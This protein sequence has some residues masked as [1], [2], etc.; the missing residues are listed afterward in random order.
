MTQKS[1]AD[2]F[3][4]QLSLPLE[5]LKAIIIKASGQAEILRE[6]TGILQC[7]EGDL[8]EVVREQQQSVLHLNEVIQSFQDRGVGP[9]RASTSHMNAAAGNEMLH[10]KQSLEILRKREPLQGSPVGSS[11]GSQRISVGHPA[12]LKSTSEGQSR[13]SSTQSSLAQSRGELDDSSSQHKCCSC[14]SGSQGHMVAQSADV[15]SGLKEIMKAQCLTE[16]VKYNGKNS[17]GDFLRMMD[18]KYPK[19]AWTDSERRDILVT[20]LEGQAKMLY[21]TLPKEVKEGPYEGIV[22]ELKAARSTPGE[23]LKLLKEWDSLQKKESETVNDFCYRM[24]RLSRKLHAEADRDF[25]LGSKLYQCL[26]N[27]R[28]AYHMLTELDR[29]DGEV[30]QAVR[31]AALRLE[32]TQQ[33]QPGGKQI[34]KKDGRGDQRSPNWKEQAVRAG[35]RSKESRPKC[36]GCGEEGHVVK[37]CPKQV[38]KDTKQRK[39]PGPSQTLSKIKDVRMEAQSN[40]MTEAYGKPYICNITIFGIIAKA[41]IDTGSVISIVPMGLLK[42]AQNNG[43]DLDGMVKVMDWCAKRPIVD[44]SGNTMSFLKLIATDVELHGAQL[45]CVQL[46][47]QNSPESLVLL[48]TNALKALGVDIRLSRSEAQAKEDK[49]ASTTARVSGR[50]V[51]PPGAASVL[52]VTSPVKEGEQVFNSS[53]ERVASGVCRI[54]DNVAPL[55]VINRGSESWVIHEGQP[56][57]EWSSETWYDPRT[58]DIPGDML[59]LNRSERLSHTERRAFLMRML[60]ENRRSGA[61]PEGL[62]KLVEEYEDVF[63]VSDLELSQTDLIKHDIDVGDA[64]PIRQ[65]TRPVPYAMRV[66]VDRMLKD[67]KMREVIEDSQSPS[68]RSSRTDISTIDYHCPGAMAHGE[69]YLSCHVAVEWSNIVMEPPLPELVFHSIFELAR[70][71]TILRQTHV[72]AEWR[73]A[74]IADTEYITLSPT[75][76]GFAISFFR[77]QCLHL[78]AFSRRMLAP[79]TA[80]EKMAHPPRH[81]EDPFDLAKM[82]D[83]AQKWSFAH[84][85]RKGL[86]RELPRLKTLI[87]LPEGFYTHVEHITN[88]HQVAYAYTHP[89]SIKAEWLLGEWSAIVVFS[90]TYYAG[91]R[92]WTKPWELIL[93]VVARGAELILLPGP[94]DDFEWGKGVDMLRDLAEE[95]IEQR[96]SLAQRIKILL[97][98]KA[99]ASNK[100]HPMFAIEGKTTT[101]PRFYTGTSARKFFNATL[102]FHV[103]YL[104][105][106][107][108]KRRLPEEGQR[109]VA[110]R[111]R[112]PPK[113]G[114]FYYR[115]PQGHKFPPHGRH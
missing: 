49:V 96:P 68:R 18:F 78:A 99:D 107:P 57:G 10:V 63:A 11:H 83:E 113:R 21:R 56:L 92:S 5:E 51:I 110:E 85:W 39:Q 16:V 29:A 36:Y 73:T 90:S 6:L 43:V 53:D 33:P 108:F 105:L 75:S 69:Q 97:P 100:S 42:H 40:G 59:E 101:Q 32:R 115:G 62:V 64:A 93:G 31:K 35:A 34:L 45:A 58:K 13:R 48:G 77:A 102:E 22:K 54:T 38:A 27:W 89:H 41:M 74:S 65:R 47:I 3:L 46:H 94:H 88:E 15:L 109:E 84:P 30:Y 91:T 81:S 4:Q 17:L 72:P 104:S 1:E 114:R 19:S 70:A 52:L 86:W 112:G 66:E 25:L 12:P 9:Q 67:L 44:A 50:Y 28:D 7:S 20:L 23:R 98:R 71:V 26:A 2:E 55:S 24:E 61:M 14:E 8:T 80:Q 82:F 37:K 60:D 111:G 87:L 106:E 79:N 103:P 76:L 95:T